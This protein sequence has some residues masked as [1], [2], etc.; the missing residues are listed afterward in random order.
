VLS[1]NHDQLLSFMTLLSLR[2][3]PNTLEASGSSPHMSSHHSHPR[4]NS[5]SPKATGMVSAAMDPRYLSYTTSDHRHISGSSHPKYHS[6]SSSHDSSRNNNYYT[7]H[8]SSQQL[9][10]P[11]SSR[12]NSY[13]P[14]QRSVQ[15]FDPENLQRPHPNLMP[16]L[17]TVFFQRNDFPF[18]SFQDV[19][20]DF[21]DQRLS[22]ILANCIAAMAS[23]MS[24]LPELSIQ[25]LHNVSE[26]YIDVA[27]VNPHISVLPLLNFSPTRTC[28]LRLLTFP[29]WKL[30]I[31][32]Y[33]SPGLNTVTIGYLASAPFVGWRL[34]WLMTLVFKILHQ[35][36]CALVN[37]SV[38]AGGQQWQL[39]C[40]CI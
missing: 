13:Q 32:L 28:S 36:R 31:R 11:S 21:W 19:S 1:S 27:K 2:S 25:G 17:I 34:K 14:D 7:G 30:Y 5:H 15:L 18:L 3:E 40:N 39:L 22:S 9:H 16:H 23:Q 29:P 10:Y 35:L 4:S 20:A 37:T 6:H 26:S 8:S 24:N 12:S 33:F 38:T